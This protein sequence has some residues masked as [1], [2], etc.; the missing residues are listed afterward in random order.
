MYGKIHVCLKNLVLTKFD[1]ETWNKILKESEFDETTDFLMFKS[2]PDERTM[3]L[4]TSVCNVSGLPIETVLEVFGQCWLTFCMDNGY[5]EML[6][7]LGADFTSFVQNLDALHA[8]LSRTYTKLLYP[9]FRCE[10]NNDGT[11]TLHYYS[12]RVGLYYIV[13]GIIPSLA[14]VLY[15]QKAQITLDQVIKQDKDNGILDEHAIFTVKL[16]KMD[17]EAIQISNE[18]PCIKPSVPKQTLIHSKQFCSIFP[19]HIVFDPEFN[20]KQCGSMIQLLLKTRIE[21]GIK[22]TSLFELTHPRVQLSLENIKSFINSAFMLSSIQKR[23]GHRLILKGQMRW[24]EDINHMIFISSPCISSLEE[25]KA[26]NIYISDIP[27]Y[28]VTRELILLNQQR[29]A[30]MEIAKRLDET[31]AALTTM[32]KA[33][34]IEKKKT[35]DLLHE[36][37]PTK[38]ATELLAG[39][40]VDAEKFESVTILF[41]DIVTFTNIASACTPMDIVN[42]LNNMYQRFDNLTTIHNVYKVETI[43]DAYM[44]VSG[45]PTRTQT[46]AENVAN[47]SLDMV[48]EAGKVQ[49]P[50]TGKSIQI[51]VGFHSG[52][53]VAGV[54]GIKMPRY[55]LFGDTVNTSSRMES[56]GIPSRVHVSPQS[57][58]LLIEKGYVFRDRGKTKIKGKGAMNTYILINRSGKSY[59]EPDDDYCQRPIAKTVD[60]SIDVEMLPEKN[61]DEPP[62]TLPIEHVQLKTKSMSDL[63][64]PI[65]RKH[66]PPLHQHDSYTCSVS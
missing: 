25:L 35:D 3:K 39:R 59:I 38:V 2:Y 43:G 54:V 26:M 41:S 52:S 22:V 40:T 62:Q 14:R 28:D 30:E 57:A 46:H 34:E 33:L 61:K 7:T 13:L 23:N 31:T 27:L 17:G 20:I 6:R 4:I 65:Q 60:M 63:P 18:I 37:L 10:T 11:L 47:F 55:C 5:E 21:K 15:D 51:R 50:A 19:Y 45:V 8:H 9:S 42:L 48:V 49:S 66:P 53:V 64:I 36:M 24:M 12:K 16:T 44:V 32:S 1:E 58:K 29:M 56:H